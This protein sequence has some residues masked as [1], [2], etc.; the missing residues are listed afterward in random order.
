[1]YYLATLSKAKP[2]HFFPKL[3]FL[4]NWKTT[5]E[6][7]IQNIYVVFPEQILGITLLFKSQE[8]EH[9]EL[10]CPL[11]SPPDTLL[12]TLSYETIKS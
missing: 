3:T 11:E 2:N 6:G 12:D 1:M 5:W 7:R 9:A 8:K 4:Q 10:H